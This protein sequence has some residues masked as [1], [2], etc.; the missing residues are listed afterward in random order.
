MRQSTLTDSHYNF[1]KDTFNGFYYTGLPALYR[2][3]LYSATK[4]NNLIA[5]ITTKEIN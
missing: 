5:L 4:D 3:M 1:M 2:V